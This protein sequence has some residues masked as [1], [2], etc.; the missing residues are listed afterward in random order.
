MILLTKIDVCQH[1]KALTI[2]FPKRQTLISS[3]VKEFTH[4]SSEFE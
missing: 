1:S 2:L 3:K 4:D